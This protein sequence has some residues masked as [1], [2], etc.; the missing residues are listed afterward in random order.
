[1]AKTEPIN[2]KPAPPTTHPKKKYSRPIFTE[3]TR[4][5]K[6]TRT[7]DPSNRLDDGSQLLRPISEKFPGYCHIWLFSANVTFRAKS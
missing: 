6:L 3:Y 4:G 5:G 7:V 2:P 1:V